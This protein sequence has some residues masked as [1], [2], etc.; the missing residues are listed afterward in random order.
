MAFSLLHA[1]IRF[2]L[3]R[4]PRDPLQGEAPAW[5]AGQL[6]AAD[7]GPAGSSVADAFAAFERDRTDPPPPGQPRRA[8]QLFL[9]ETRALADWAVATDSPFRER[10]VWFWANHFTIS[11]RRFAVAPLVGAYVREAIRP[12]VTGRFSDMLLAVMRHPAML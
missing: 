7:P 9:A 1:E 5:L 8:R 11:Q 6:E 12:Y 4:R 3:G 10:L 2:G